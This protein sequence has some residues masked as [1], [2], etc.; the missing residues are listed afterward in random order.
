MI[1][2][3]V[4]GLTC[5]R[6]PCLL[7]RKQ[8]PC[9]TR[10]TGCHSKAATL[11]LQLPDLRFS[12]EANLVTTTAALHPFG[13]SH[14]LPVKR[15]HGFHGSPAE[16]MFSRLELLDLAALAGFGGRD[17]SLFRIGRRGV[18]LAMTY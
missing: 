3:H 15:G 11:L 5:L 16:S 13:E 7:D 4:A 8:V 10:V 6:L 17:Q 12:L 14:W 9:M 1:E 2:T 18:L